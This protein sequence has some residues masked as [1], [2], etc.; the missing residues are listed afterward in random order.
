MPAVQ[1][2]PPILRLLILAALLLLSIAAILHADYA[3]RQRA[4]R[5]EAVAPATLE[6]LRKVVGPPDFVHA[7]ADR[8]LWVYCRHTPYRMCSGEY[9]FIARLDGRIIESRTV[10]CGVRL[11]GV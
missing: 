5:L 1:P 10:G 6:E 3:D 9:H 2:R 11:A 7:S 8:M 4:L